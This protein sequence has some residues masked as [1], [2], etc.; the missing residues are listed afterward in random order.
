LPEPTKRWVAARR[1]KPVNEMRVRLYE[2]LMEA[3]EQIAR[4]RYAHGVTHESVLVALDAAETQPSDDERREDLYLSSL[5]AYVRALGG[6]LEIR[7]VFPDGT[8]VLQRDL[9]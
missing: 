5:S 9:P 8:L 4:A 6:Q 7:A 1:E 3:Q 2:R